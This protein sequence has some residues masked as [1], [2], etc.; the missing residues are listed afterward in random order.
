MKVR[1]AEK[2]KFELFNFRKIE[3]FKIHTFVEI[4]H[5]DVEI[6]N[7]LTCVNHKS[8]NVSE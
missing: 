3:N 7:Q 1:N 2:Q 6:Q 5:K 8:E 4:G